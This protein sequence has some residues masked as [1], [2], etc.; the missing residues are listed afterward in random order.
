MTDKF[1]SCIKR[2]NMLQKGDTVTVALS[3]GADSVA[4]L[5]LM[6]ANSETF[7]ITLKA[8]H[9]NHNLRGAESDRDEQFV[10]NLCEEWGIPLILKSVDV[11][12]L[13]KNSGESVELAARK[14]RYDFFSEIGGKIATAHTASDN[15]ETVLFNITRGTG[16]KGVAGI[17]YVREQYIRPLRFC[18]RAEVEEHC[19]KNNLS[20]VTDSTNLS[21]D[22][23]RNKI[24]HNVLPVLKQINP[25]LETAF[26][27]LSQSAAEDNDYIEQAAKEYFASHYGNSKI[28]LENGIHPALVS[29]VIALL[30]SSVTGQSAD[31]DH[32]TEIRQSL[33]TR[34]RV[35]VRGGYEAVIS[36]REIK[37]VPLNSQNNV[38]FSVTKRTLSREN[39]EKEL[40]I[41][42]LLLKNAIDCDKITD[43]VT[44]RTREEGDTIKLCGRGTKTLKKLY[45]EARI[46]QEE[47]SALP[48]AADSLGVL[49]VCGVGVSQRVRVD[50]S[51]RNI[52]IFDVIK[53]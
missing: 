31:S 48:V 38:Q 26:L 32:I 7:G 2:Y 34:T 9:L 17:P 53:Q 12:S 8:A 23:T 49:W 15:A 47:R 30:I 45:N 3:G 21:D 44:L 22:Y 52:M 50:K 13:A 5:H 35:S 24:R 29:R 16:I 27:R 40:K 25:S 36:N 43:N 33:G 28:V 1:L 46:P 19:K 6:L 37:I 20:F 10:R 11:S 18:S 42:K 41:N 39:F 4:L 14:A 51:T